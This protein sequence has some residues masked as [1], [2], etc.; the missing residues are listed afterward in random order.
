M[1]NF[2][3]LLIFTV[4]SLLIVF[5]SISFAFTC[6]I[7]SGSCNAAEICIFSLYKQ[8][9]SHAA[10]CSTYNYKVCC[11]FSSSELRASCNADE[12]GI[13]TLNK[14]SNSHVEFYG[15]SNYHNNVCVKESMSCNIKSFCEADE[16]CVVSFFRDLNS[17]AA[18]CSYYDNKLCCKSSKYYMI[19]GIALYYDTGLPIQNGV[20]K[21]IIKETGESSYASISSDGSFILKFNSTVNASKN[22]FTLGLIVNSSDNKMGYTQLIAGG[23]NFVSSTQTCSIKQWH[24]TGKA[25]DSSGALI[26]S[27]NVMISVQSELQTYTNSTSFN[28]GSWDIYI[29]PCLIPGALYTFQ[30]TILSGDKTSSIYLMQ[31]AK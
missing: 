14:I 18:D 23:G 12:V 13:V 1:N 2:Q 3:I 15:L 20:I 6:T 21:G 19:K 24:F 8:T 31:I 7:R 10:D 25:V 16:V 11:D 9:N 5:T 17:H 30:I 29:S 4:F 26:S 22:K 27:G 28:N